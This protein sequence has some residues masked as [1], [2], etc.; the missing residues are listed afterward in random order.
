VFPDPVLTAGVLQADVSG[1]GN[2]TELVASV[3]VPVQIGGQRG[4]RI[5]AASAARSVAE[6][7]FEEYLRRL[8]GAA[9]DAYIDALHARLTRARK[10]ATLQSLKELVR[11]NELRFAAGDIGESMLIQSR[12]EE[13]QFQAEVLSA[14][15][16]LRGADLALLQLLGAEGAPLCDAALDVRGSMEAAAQRAFA[17]R[18]LLSAANRE[19]PDVLA[20][21]LAIDA[22]ARQLALARA[23]RVPDLNV[24]VGYVHFF[25]SGATP[26]AE[27]LTATLSVPLPFSK[28]YRGELDAA[29][30]AVEQSRRS[31]EGLNLS[32]ETGVR[33]ALASFEANAARVALYRGILPK[34]DAV[35][36]KTLFNYQRGG[37]SLVEVLVAQRTDN[38]VHLAYGDA[39]AATAHALVA[40]ELASGLWDLDLS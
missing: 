19:R 40:L 10:Q 29:A 34:A 22:S 27:V 36:A 7:T 24:G 33:A 13:E 35:L 39:L 4:A 8:R 32:V 28:V 38:D 17:L 6:A 37:A 15:G 5:D 2:P 21:R 30:H 12:V 9:A 20:A 14:E 23:N 1:R 26:P 31:S 16:D 3:A 25:A 11:V 18:P